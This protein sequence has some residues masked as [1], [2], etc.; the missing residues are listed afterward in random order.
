MVLE[1]CKVFAVG[2]DCVVEQVA[3]RYRVVRRDTLQL[4]RVSH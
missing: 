4:R 1:E 2:K 3:Y